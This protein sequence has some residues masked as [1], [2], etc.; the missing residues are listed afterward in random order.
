MNKIPASARKKIADLRGSEIAV[1][2]GEGSFGFEEYLNAKTALI[3]KRKSIQSSVEDNQLRLCY[4]HGDGDKQ[5]LE[6]E[7]FF[8]SAVLK[9]RGGDFEGCFAID[10]TDYLSDTENRDFKRLMSYIRANRNIYFVLMLFSENQAEVRKFFDAASEYASFDLVEFEYPKPGVL[11]EYAAER[12]EEKYGRPLGDDL[13]D[14]IYNLLK[15]GKHEFDFIDLVVD[16]LTNRETSF[17]DLEKELTSIILD[18]RSEKK[19]TKKSG[20]N[21]GFSAES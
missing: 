9:S 17:R 12:I 21:F 16:D 20:L 6:I 8:S 7:L 19:K 18:E 5:A 15:T 3:I 10:M 14:H 2:P 1:F 13:K 4:P 11:A